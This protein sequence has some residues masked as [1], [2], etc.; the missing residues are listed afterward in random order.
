MGTLTFDKANRALA[1]AASKSLTFL[2][3]RCVGTQTTHSRRVRTHAHKFRNVNC[4]LVLL[5][6]FATALLP[7]MGTLAVDKADRALAIAAC[8]RRLSLVFLL[9][10]HK[11]RTAEGRGRTPIN[12][13]PLISHW[14]Y[15]YVFATLLASMGTP[16]S[17]WK[18]AKQVSVFT[19]GVCGIFCGNTCPLQRERAQ[20]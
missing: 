17:H 5:L 14:F 2:G 6:C 9:W 16:I 7:S 1:I 4:P 15:S 13:E 10:G 12:S 18:H 11:Q 20:K 19:G 8:S 3:L